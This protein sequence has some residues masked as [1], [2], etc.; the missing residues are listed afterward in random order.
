MEELNWQPFEA[1]QTLQRTGMEGGTILLDDEH[2]AGA[3]ITLEAECLR[4]PYAVTCGVYGWLVHTRFFTDDESAQFAV[5]EMKPVLE[6]IVLMLPDEDDPA[7]DVKMDAVSDAI[8]A[9]SERFP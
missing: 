8:S 2:P 6:A 9:F 3:R 7:P 4:A 5:E 1:G